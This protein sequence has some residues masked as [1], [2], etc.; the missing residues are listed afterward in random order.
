ME[1]VLET[2]ATQVP[3]LVV[4]VILA[5]IFL[6]SGK[7]QAESFGKVLADQRAQF[8]DALKLRDDRSE[9]ITEACHAV[10]R[11]ATEAVRENTKLVGRAEGTIAGTQKTL[12]S[13]Q[14]IMLDT[15]RLLREH[16]E[17]ERHRP[18]D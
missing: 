5:I 16:A 3:A 14:T 10:A 17:R 6:R 1:K 11:E 7:E 4:L 13:T 18:K 9:D 12:E 8:V 15:G 2:A